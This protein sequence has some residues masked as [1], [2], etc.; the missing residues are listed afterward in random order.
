MHKDDLISS[1]SEPSEHVESEEEDELDD[2]LGVADDI[3]AD[4]VDELVLF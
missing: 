4:E 1:G 3:E 2:D